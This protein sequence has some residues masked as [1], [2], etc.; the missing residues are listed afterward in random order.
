[1]TL[2]W[3]GAE[4]FS[5]DF[6]SLRFFG[7]GPWARHPWG[8][9]RVLTDAPRTPT[10]PTQGRK[11]HGLEA[12]RWGKHPAKETRLL[13]RHLEE[14]WFPG[15]ACHALVASLF[16]SLFA[17]K[18]EVP[19]VGASFGVPPPLPL[20]QNLPKTCGGPVLLLGPCWGP[21]RTPHWFGHANHYL[22]VSASPLGGRGWWWARSSAWQ[23]TCHLDAQGWVRPKP[24]F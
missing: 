19:H 18:R 7:V 12:W 9:R 4:E 3:H 6:F 17:G 23:P 15:H 20:A 16:A 1:M 10:A 5:G 2:R 13:T 14:V 24:D 21:N 8:H 22:K 11:G